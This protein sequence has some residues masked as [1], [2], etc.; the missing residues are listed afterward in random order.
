[1][2]FMSVSVHFVFWVTS[3]VE[4]QSR[5]EDSFPFYLW[6]CWHTYSVTEYTPW[7][8]IIWSSMAWT[9]SASHASCILPH[10]V[11]VAVWSNCMQRYCVASQR[12]YFYT[13][14]FVIFYAHFLF[15]RKTAN[16]VHKYFIF[17]I[18]LTNK[19]WFIFIQKQE[20]P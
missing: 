19:R 6:L 14:P 11:I 20:N 3:L 13:L 1:M 18:Y 10:C 17:F 4:R 8:S 5:C 12:G 9:F 2:L 7:K 15:A 16:S